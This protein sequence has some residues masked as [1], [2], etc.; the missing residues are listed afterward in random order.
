[1][2]DRFSTISIN[3]EPQPPVKRPKRAKPGLRKKVK[4]PVHGPKKPGRWLIPGLCIPVF[5]ISLY[6]AVGFFLAPSL[7]TGYI[8]DSLQQTANIGLT[9]GQAR[10]NPFTLQ[11][12]LNDIVSTDSDQ[13]QT[14]ATKLLQIDQLLIDLNLIALLRNGLTCNRLDIQGMTVSL[15]RHPD[16]S[17][18]LPTLATEDTSGT[19]TDSLSRLPLLFSLNNITIRDSRVL[20]DDRLAGKK[21]SVE[22]IKLDL[23]TFSNYSF[24][25]REYIQPHFSALINGSPVELTGEAT[26]PGENGP[27]ELKTNLSCNVQDIDLPLY[28]AYLPESVPLLLNKGK[29]NGKIHVSFIPEDKKGGRLTI[30]FQLTTTEIELS[31][32]EQ[33][34]SMTAPTIEVEGSLQPLDGDLHIQNLRVLQPQLSAETAHFPRD[35][36]QLFSSS[37]TSEETAEQQQPGLQIDSLTVEDGSLQL[38]KKQQETFS[39]TWSTIQLQVK[40]FRL[41][42]EQSGTKGTFALSARQVKSKASFDWQGSFNKRGI[43]GGALQ[44]NNIEVSSLL[45]FMDGDLAADASGSARL[46]GNFSFDPTRRNSGMTS[47]AD[48]TTEIHD[49][50]LLDQK[51]PWLSARKVQI[52][53]SHYKEDDLDLGTIVLEESTLTLQQNKLPQF[54]TGLGDNKKRFLIQGLVFSG[55]ASLYP[56]K[57]KE[58]VLQLAELRI[59]ASKL[60]APES[61]NNF[62]LTA[63]INEQGTLK[64]QGLA[65][66]AP[67][68]ASLSLL[69]AA[70]S[71][72]QIAPWL[73]EAPLFQQSRATIGGQGAYRY[74]ESSFTGSVQLH[75]ALFRNDTKSA[76]LAVNKAEM[77][78]VTIKSKPLRIGMNELILDGPKLTWLQ[79]TDSPNPFEQIGSFLQDLAIS[80]ADKKNQQKD[81]AHSSLPAIQKI[82]FDNG[83]ISYTD[84][85]L[86][87]PWSTEISQ[88]KGQINTLQEK[89]APGSGFDLSGQL[90]TVPFTLSGSADLLTRQGDFTTDF[91]LKGFPLLLLAEQISP[92]L[93]LNPDS[94]SFDLSLKHTRQ[95]G[96]EQGEATF[97]FTGLRPGSAQADTALPLALLADNKDQMQVLIPMTTNSATSLFKQTVAIFQT[98]IV[99]AGVAPLLLA[100]TEFADLQDRQFVTFA[101][102]SSELDVIGDENIQVTLQHFADLLA[103][104]PHLGLVLTGMAD[105]IHDGAV[106]LKALEEKE[107][108]RVAQKNEQRLE[109]WQK[110]EK[111]RQQTQQALQAQQAAAAPG[112]ILEQNIP[113]EDG[114]PAPLS[115]EPVTVSDTTLQ[116]LA[117]ERA[118][119]IYDFYATLPGIASG[120]I[121]LQEKT[122][123]S[124]AEAAGNQVLIDLKPVF[125]NIH[126]I[127]MP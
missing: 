108:K 17:Y 89:A 41:A 86:S 80:A 35:M 126:H 70:I 95:T 121:A 12:Q 57:D 1:M 81:G 55:N 53:G 27:N 79:E 46:R 105:P 7:L 67:L 119:Q 93:D 99:K 42:P 11:L 69:F 84:Q 49:L 31:N 15:I 58:P 83:T 50:I 45:A 43:P 24:E 34:L 123:L 56:Q 92:L 75:S 72:E 65:T 102:G 101:A 44:V 106:I 127:E 122:R 6:G 66:L 64:A 30:G 8:S 117:Q 116:D 113:A 74:P 28:F 107:R 13:S 109:E 2:S 48:A 111:I 19:E 51:K 22:Q 62:E 21:H 23:P 20:F 97:L 26:L 68:R 91:N 77:K 98:Q 14:P 3:P 9:A 78:D 85:R 59:K 88:L 71:S 47:L 125:Q 96:E 18:N 115:P 61:Q 10:F 25:A 87:P 33:T 40:N 76:G 124:E 60:A 37:A 16:K 114:P 63:R 32:T 4:K 36:A 94:G 100:G 73:P 120:R 39:P 104:R 112:K 38:N 90:N 118:L 103:A 52:K 82:S 5:L 54:L 29:G 110:K